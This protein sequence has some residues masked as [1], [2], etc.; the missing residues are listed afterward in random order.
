MAAFAAVLDFASR[1]DSSGMPPTLTRKN[2]SPCK[3]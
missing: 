1:D 2:A 3:T